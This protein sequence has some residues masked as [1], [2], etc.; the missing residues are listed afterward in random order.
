MND[1]KIL[2]GV[3]IATLGTKKFNFLKVVVLEK[4]GDG[5]HIDKHRP[6]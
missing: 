5:S 1:P 4:R 3:K 2:K 6:K